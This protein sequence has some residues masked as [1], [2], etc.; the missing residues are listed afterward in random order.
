MK[1]LI[2]SA[3]AMLGLVGAGC[4]APSS[5]AKK[6]SPAVYKVAFENENVRV[7]E[8]H[9]GSQKDICGFGMH[10]HPAHLYIMKTDAKLRIVTPDGKES[11]ENAQAGDMGWATAEKHICEN[12]MGNDAA[13]YIIEIKDK[14]WKPSTGL[15]R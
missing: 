15:T 11:F 9:T 10:T 6:G 4:Q 7:L 2:L 13:C 5:V 8:Y 14:D 12:L 3:V 1:T